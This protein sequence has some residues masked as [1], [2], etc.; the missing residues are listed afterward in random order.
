MLDV[1]ERKVNV[2][3]KKVKAVAEQFLHQNS[4]SLKIQ[5]RWFHAF[6]SK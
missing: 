6:E 5:V 3:Q 2:L 4:V 1:K